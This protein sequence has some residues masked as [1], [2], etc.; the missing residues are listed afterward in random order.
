MLGNIIIGSVIFG[1][2]SFAL[3]R[4]VR[5]AKDGKCAG[6]DLKSQCQSSCGQEDYLS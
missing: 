3:V 4:F 5:K 1:Y 6:C 2:A